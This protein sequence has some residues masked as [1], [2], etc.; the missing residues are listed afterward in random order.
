[1]DGGIKTVDDPDP[2]SC[3]PPSGSLHVILSIFQD[4][5]KIFMDGGIRTVDDPDQEI[6]LK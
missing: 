4:Y 5:H 2:Q 3:P 1:M 6:F